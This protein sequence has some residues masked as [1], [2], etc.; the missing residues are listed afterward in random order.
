MDR[1]RA[2]AIA[3]ERLAMEGIRGGKLDRLAE[4]AV[5]MWETGKTSQFAL[6]QTTARLVWEA[7]SAIT[8]ASRVSAPSEASQRPAETA[9]PAALPEEEGLAAVPE[10]IKATQVDR[11]AWWL[12][13][14]LE[15]EAQRLG[16]VLTDDEVDVLMTRLLYAHGAIS[17]SEARELNNKVVRIARSAMEREKAEGAATVQ[18][19]KSLSI[20]A[21]WARAYYILYDTESS[22]VLSGALQNAM[23]ENTPAGET[24]PW[25]SP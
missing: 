20:P 17:P 19:R 25:R 11:A 21:G 24:E 22:L 13:D 15:A 10:G 12:R 14:R 7:A 3:R 5:N 18:V 9:P 1:R 4:K 8:A 2:I 23:L 6:S 16:V